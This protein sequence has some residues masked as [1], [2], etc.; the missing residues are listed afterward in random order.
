M[1]EN[2]VAVRHVEDMEVL[3][4][5]VA[6]PF[7]DLVSALGNAAFPSLVVLPGQLERF[8]G[9]AGIRDGKLT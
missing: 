4:E 3:L 9:I 7:Y 6:E 1:Y 2:V 8:A 5:F